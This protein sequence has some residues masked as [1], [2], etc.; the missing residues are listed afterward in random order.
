MGRYFFLLF[1]YFFFIYELVSIFF[2]VRLGS[3]EV[4]T[5][6]PEYHLDVAAKYWNLQVGMVIVHVPQ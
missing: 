6:T 3:N 5:M 2:P 1:L 4:R